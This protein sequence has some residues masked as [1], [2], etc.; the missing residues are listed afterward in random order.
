[1]LDSV[2]VILVIVI[3]LVVCRDAAD[4][5]NNTTFCSQLF[6]VLAQAENIT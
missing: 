4:D 1:M 6:T 5:A 3:V 2:S